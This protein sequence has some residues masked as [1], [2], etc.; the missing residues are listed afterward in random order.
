[1]TELGGYEDSV[2]ASPVLEASALMDQL[3]AFVD[4]EADAKTAVKS[5]FFLS[6]R[7]TRQ[8]FRKTGWSRWPHSETTSPTRRARENA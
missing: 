8:A 2:A 3:A 4:D 5:A 7:D 1:M 6:S